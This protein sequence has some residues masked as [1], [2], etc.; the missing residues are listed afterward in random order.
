MVAR[1]PFCQPYSSET[2]ATIMVKAGA[3]RNGALGQAVA[4]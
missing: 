2:L 4:G 3:H 1:T